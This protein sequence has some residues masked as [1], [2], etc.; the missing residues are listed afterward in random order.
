MNLKPI[1]KNLLNFMTRLQMRKKQ[2]IIISETLKEQNSLEI[3]NIAKNN[4]EQLLEAILEWIENKDIDFEEFC[5]Y[6]SPVLLERLKR[7]CIKNNVVI[8]DTPDNESG[9]YKLFL[10]L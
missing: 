7:E 6:V 8:D 2:K 3:E 9:L 4:Q 10:E 5:D 1:L